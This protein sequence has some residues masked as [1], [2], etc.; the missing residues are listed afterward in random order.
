[1]NEVYII[2]GSKD[3]SIKAIVIGEDD[4]DKAIVFTIENAHDSDVNYI[5]KV[6][7]NEIISCGND[8]TIKRWSTG[9]SWVSWKSFR[10]TK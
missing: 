9:F 1:M 5:M 8:G 3:K 10:F 7:E 6:C 4:M 2:T